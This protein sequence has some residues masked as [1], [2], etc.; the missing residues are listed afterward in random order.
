MHNSKKVAMYAVKKIDSWQTRSP[1]IILI[2]ASIVG[3]LTGLLGSLFQIGIQYII[4]LRLELT[5]STFSNIYLK[6]LLV[7]TV[8]AL[9][10]GFA[11]YLVKRFAPESGGSGIPE[12]EGAL[13]DLRPVRWWRVLPVKFFGG[14]AA[15]GSGMVLGREG[16]TVQM[17]SN[18]GKMVSDTCHLKNKDSQHTLIATGAGAGITTAFN[19][20]LSGILFVIEEMKGE[21]TYTKASIKAV[22]VGC[23]SACV[24]YQ[25]I[26]G[27]APIL[28]IPAQN[29]VSMNSI[30]LYIFLG[31]AL[32]VIGSLS[33]FLILT[34]RKF[35]DLFY[36]K[37]EYLFV[38]TGALL[39]GTFGLLTMFL[40]EITGGGFDLVPNL[41]NEFYGFYPLLILFAL[42]LIA[43]ILCF[44]SGAPGGIFS[45]TIALGAILGVLFGIMAKTIFPEYDIQLSTCAV[46]GMAGLFAASIRAPLTGIVIVME[47]TSS[48]ILILPLIL[49]CVSAT[50]M[51]QTLGSTS[52]YSAI[53]ENTLNKLGIEPNQ[54]D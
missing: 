3:A 54:K 5:G 29:A 32:G 23:V 4:S 43:T 15:L 27:S 51:A 24:V 10:G 20:P 35:L 41:M 47:M 2:L 1:F 22:F 50:F 42:R 53:L 37:K 48:Y 13:L 17:G 49:T 46:L 9:M 39:A 40:P 38:L 31:L 52:L 21:F 26:M 25:L 30:W 33:N 14:L 6:S 12:V 18:L 28:N 8:T 11:Y 19:A 7:F 36:Q 16:P 34:T 44:G 45:P